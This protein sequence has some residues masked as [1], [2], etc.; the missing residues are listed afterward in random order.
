MGIS[1]FQRIST[2]CETR[3]PFKHANYHD[4]WLQNDDAVY[5]ENRIWAH[6]YFAELAYFISLKIGE[7]IYCYNYLMRFLKRGLLSIISVFHYR[8]QFREKVA[9]KP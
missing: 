9:H 6:P 3:F 5:V 4:D 7:G 2:S 8:Q 1:F